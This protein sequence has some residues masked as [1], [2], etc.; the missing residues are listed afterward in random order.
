MSFQ[1]HVH[2][3]SM[4]NWITKGQVPMFWQP[5]SSRKLSG[6]PTHI[7]GKWLNDITHHISHDTFLNSSFIVYEPC[8]WHKASH[9][10]SSAMVAVTVTIFFGPFLV[11]EGMWLLPLLSTPWGTT[12]VFYVSLWGPRSMRI[13]PKPQ[14][15]SFSPPSCPKGVHSSDLPWTKISNQH[16]QEQKNNGKKIMVLMV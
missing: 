11:D 1:E 7:P 15:S 3:W 9:H 6:C 8:H 13:S 5:N 10:C 14:G 12:C 16:Q 4:W 2:G